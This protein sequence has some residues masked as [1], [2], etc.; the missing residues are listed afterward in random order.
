VVL[1][2][3]GPTHGAVILA[4]PIFELYVTLAATATVAAV[5]GLAL[6]AT[7]KSQDQILPMLVVSVM[8]SIVFSGGLIP[9]TGR[10]VLDQLSWVIPARWGFAAS[11]STVDLSNVAP[12]TPANET[13]WTHDATA[14]LVNMI[15]LC[16]LGIVMAAIVRWRIRLKALCKNTIRSARHRL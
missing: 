15:T 9:V 2:K 10:L 6:S 11:A 3:G 7:A 5:T 1:G 14:W 12:L 8:L 16:A 13:L 4:N